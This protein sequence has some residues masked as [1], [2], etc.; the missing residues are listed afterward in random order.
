M[1]V[2]LFHCLFSG[3]IIISDIIPNHHLIN[4]R[5]VVESAFTGIIPA[6]SQQL[7]QKKGKRDFRTKLTDPNV[8]ALLHKR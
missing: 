5:A 6:S 8:C 2:W 1:F 7:K 3:S 4:T